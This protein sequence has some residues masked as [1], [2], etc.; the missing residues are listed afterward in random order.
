MET[1]P[2]HIR[3]HMWFQHARAP[4]QYGRRVR[5]HL[6]RVFRHQWIGHGGLVPW[7]PRFPDFN[8][9]DSFS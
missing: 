4:S 2:Q 8:S 1:V 3:C 7:P 9:I 5:E 6:N